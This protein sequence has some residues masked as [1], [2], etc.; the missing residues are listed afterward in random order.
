MFVTNIYEIQYFLCLKIDTK[1]LYKNDILKSYND[2]MLNFIFAEN[3]RKTIINSSTNNVICANKI[4][5]KRNCT[6]GLKTSTINY[7]T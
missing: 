4:V 6:K 7:L 1:L 3:F 5:P 2:R